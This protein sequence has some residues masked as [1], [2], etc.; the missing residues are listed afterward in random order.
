MT[1]AM[2]V[3]N[4]KLFTFHALLLSLLY[5][6][7]VFL[8]WSSLSWKMEH[9][10]P[11]L[12]YVAWLMNTQGSIPYVDIFETSMLGSFIFHASIGSLFGYDDFAFRVVDLSLLSGLLL[13]TY[14][15]IK[16]FGQLP[17]L[18]AVVLFG[19]FYFIKGPIMSL[20]RDYIGIMPIALSLLFIPKASCTLVTP[21]RFLFVGFLFACSALIKPHLAIGLPIICTV[22]IF[23]RWEYKAKSLKDFLLC[24]LLAGLGFLL[25]LLAG[26]IYLSG[27]GAVPAFID[28]FTR[29][30]PMHNGMSYSLEYLSVTEYIRYFIF[31]ILWLGGY[32]PLLVSSIFAYRHFSAVH[33]KHKRE[34]QMMLALVF[35]YAFYVM[36]AGKF[37]PYHFMPLAYFTVILSAL[38]LVVP[39]DHTSRA[40]ILRRRSLMA[41]IP[42]LLTLT[43]QGSLPKTI[44]ALMSSSNNHQ[45][46]TV[47]VDEMVQWLGARLEPEDTVQPLD[48][49]G[50]SIQAMLIAKAP[51]AT[52]F[53][54]DYHFYHHID[55]NYTKNLRAAFMQ[56]LETA[57]PRFIIQVEKEKPWVS[58]VGT[59]REFLALNKFLE[60][61]YHS[62]M[63][64]DGYQ[65]LERH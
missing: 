21:L 42:L 62:A 11:L 58:G 37:W 44:G 53:M 32:V 9:D 41:V 31:Q 7:F 1:I 57:R 65:I 45:P 19:L 55:S 8:A 18:W 5:A 48:W 39:V 29:Y 22:I 51:L 28:I 61:N 43:L 63:Q 49:T 25:P 54:Y 47:R 64:G 40:A 56:Q 60:K 16:R 6:A 14:L 10:T 23:I 26:F 34:A 33:L 59:S 17:A 35:T 36:I 38:W 30:L 24:A 46:I 20:Q 13:I 3:I 27:H 4:H 15:F 12:H 2:R 50:G 52:R